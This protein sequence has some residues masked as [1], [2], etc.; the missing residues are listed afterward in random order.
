MR[1]IEL[2]IC[3][4]RAETG[5]E[6]EQIV[7]TAESNGRAVWYRQFGA[8]RPTLL[9]ML[10]YDADT[11]LAE[12]AENAQVI[13]QQIAAAAAAHGFDSEYRLIA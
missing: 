9:A 7:V 3:I 2:Q 12:T 1:A 8:A 11:P 6:L 5:E 10:A 4:N 13:A